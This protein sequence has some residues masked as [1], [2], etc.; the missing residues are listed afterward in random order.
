[1]EAV[2]NS[3]KAMH[4]A[5]RALVARG[6]RIL[7]WCLLAL[8]I[9]GLVVLV[10]LVSNYR[11]NDDI[12]FQPEIRTEGGLKSVD[13]TAALVLR[14]VQDTS[15]A[16]NDPV[17]MPGHWLRN[18]NAFQQGLVYSQARFAYEL[19]D[20]LGRSLGATAVD[21]DLD[22]AAGLLRFP[23]NVWRF[24]FQKSWAPTVTSEAQY[25]AAARA[26]MSYNERFARGQVIFDPR[27]DN[28]S[29]TLERIESDISSQANILIQHVEQLAAGEPTLVSANEIYFSTKGRLY[30]YLMVLKALGEDFEDVIVGAGAGFVWT[31]MIESLETAATIHP[32]F[33]TSSPPGQMFLPSHPA[34]M[35]FFTLRV[36]TQMRD[37][38]AVMRDR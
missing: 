23:S 34:E 19:A 18:M 20:S 29:A 14:E 13:M 15:W 8:N 9:A 25:T 17:L 35:G 12:T 28:L 11:I 26:L 27:P 33:L 32:L 36:Q 22:R 10:A 4:P 31:Q 24:D 38:L 2:L 3:K 6:K 7:R 16:P 1:M 30:G 21:P 5:S 37:V